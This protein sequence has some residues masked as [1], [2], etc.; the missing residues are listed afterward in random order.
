VL[1][2]HLWVDAAVAVF[3]K[4]DLLAFGQTFLMLGH[5]DL[6]SKLS[7]VKAQTLVVVCEED[8]AKP[9]EV[10]PQ[11]RHLTPLEHP[12][13]IAALLAAL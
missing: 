8:Y 12:Q 4:N 6:R 1:Q 11:A 5:F 13:R 3:L 10:L 7:Q 9:L 2:A